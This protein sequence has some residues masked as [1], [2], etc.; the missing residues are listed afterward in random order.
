MLILVVVSVMLVINSGLIDKTRSSAES[1]HQAYGEESRY[2]ETFLIGT[3]EYNSISEYIDSIGEE[4]ITEPTETI[5]VVF[6]SDGTLAFSRNNSTITGKT[7]E[8]TYQVLKDDIYELNED[9]PWNDEKENITTVVF[10]DKIAPTSTQVWFR[11][12]INLTTIE[13]IANLDTRYV[14]GMYRMFADC[15]SLQSIDLS[16]FNTSNVTTMKYMFTRCTSL[17]S[18]DVSSFDTSK[19]ENMDFLFGADR[20]SPVDMALTEIIGLENFNTSSVTSM[21]GMF[22]RCSNIK[23]LNLS[24]FDTSMLEEASAMFSYCSNLKTIYVSNNFVNTNITSS[25]QM[26]ESCGAIKGQNNTTY[27]S[28]KTG[29]EYARIDQPELKGYFTDIRVNSVENKT[30]LQYIEITGTQY[31]DTEYKPNQDTKIEMSL[32]SMSWNNTFMPFGGRG[33]DPNYCVALWM[34]YNNATDNTGNYLRYGLNDNKIELTLANDYRN[35]DFDIAFE[36]GKITIGEEEITF[37]EVSD[38]TCDYNLYLGALNGG[39]TLY[40]MGRSARIYSCKIYDGDILVRDFI[41]AYNS[42]LNK[43]GLYDRVN[44]VFYRDAAGGNFIAGP[45]K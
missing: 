42:V 23:V 31:I 2:G 3:T 30:D 5:Y 10:V 9:V 16:H 36:N 14:T 4:E 18:I 29:K 35:T 7:V 12:C 27:N 26:F 34:Y 39:G 40:N 11:N 32:K 25:A 38:F 20:T 28:S 1:T 22:M 41:P 45:N 37:T 24:S 8:Q 44:G 21:K 19:V 33:G 43:A 6:Y 17:K 13:G 15:P